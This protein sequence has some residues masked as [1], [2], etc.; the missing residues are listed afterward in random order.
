MADLVYI[1]HSKNSTE[2]S[3]PAVTTADAFEDVW[4][5]KGWVLCDQSGKKVTTAD[6]AS[7]GGN[8]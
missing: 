8:Q 7:A 4:K 3:S 2:D 1:K 5:D 6:K